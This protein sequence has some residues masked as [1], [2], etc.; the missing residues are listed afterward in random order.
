MKDGIN[1]KFGI[2]K[3]CGAKCNGDDDGYDI[4][5]FCEN[6]V[7][8]KEDTSTIEAIETWQDWIGIQ[9]IIGG[10]F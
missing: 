3:G 6:D 7:P 5:R 1:E 4:C 2:C 8:V 10:A 9:D